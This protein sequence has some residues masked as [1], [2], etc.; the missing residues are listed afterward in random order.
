MG[1][2]G[3]HKETYARTNCVIP[4][5]PENSPT[6]TQQLKHYS[7]ND[8]SKNRTEKKNGVKM[9]LFHLFDVFRV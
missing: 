1:D 8:S 7:L 6:D 3:R 5:R 4:N 2:T 9:L